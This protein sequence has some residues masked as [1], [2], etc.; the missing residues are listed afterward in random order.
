ML[1]LFYFFNYYYFFLIFVFF[2]VYVCVCVCVLVFLKTRELIMSD[3]ERQKM[4]P[5]TKLKGFFFKE[6][7]EDIC[8]YL[9]W[10][11]HIY[12]YIQCISFCFFFCGKNLKVGAQ[13]K[14]KRKTPV[15]INLFCWGEGE[16]ERNCL[17]N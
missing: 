17:Q 6:R 14:K 5:F 12:A 2:F 9:A 10:R 11:T 16:G 13:K 1:Q 7:E 8:M 3:K 4:D 15:Q